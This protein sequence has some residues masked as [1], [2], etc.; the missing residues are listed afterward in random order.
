MILTKYIVL[1]KGKKPSKI[2]LDNPLPPEAIAA[3][4][5]IGNY[6]KKIIEFYN[7]I[8][9]NK[10][11][12]EDKYSMS[13]T[14]ERNEGVYTYDLKEDTKTIMFVFVDPETNNEIL[15]EWLIE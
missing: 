15:V 8:T 2:S 7:L 10:Q 1:K 12:D 6:L 5:Y 11:T 13:L 3:T 4:T 9:Q 14:I